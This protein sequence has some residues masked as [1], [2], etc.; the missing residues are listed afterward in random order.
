MACILFHMLYGTVG[1]HIV[2]VAPRSG[3]T[4]RGFMLNGGSLKHECPQT[5]ADVRPLIVLNLAL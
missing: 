4:C 5:V 3:N 1:N 2:Y